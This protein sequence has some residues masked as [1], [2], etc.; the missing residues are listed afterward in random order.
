MLIKNKNK[1]GLATLAVLAALCVAG[2]YSRNVYAANIM[3]DGFTDQIFYDCVL[4]AY[5]DENPSETI[6]ATGLTPAQLGSLTQLSCNNMD[7]VSI[8]GAETLTGA[9]S[10]GLS[11]NQISDISPIADLRLLQ[12][13]SLA[14]NNII[15]ISALANLQSLRTLSLQNNN[16]VDITAIGNLHSL[17]T[18]SLQN[19][20]ISDISALATVNHL[21][22]LNISSNYV[23]DITA[24]WYGLGSH[25]HYVLDNNAIFDFWP[26]SV[27]SIDTNKT[28]AKNQ[29]AAIFAD[30]RIVE[31]PKLFEQVKQSSGNY[32]FL[33]TSTPFTISNAILSDD[34]ASITIIDLS[35]PARI[36]INDGIAGGSTYTV[37]F[38]SNLASVVAPD[39]IE[40]VTNGSAKTAK[41][42]NLPETVA[43]VLQNDITATANVYWTLS[44]SDYDPDK[45]TAQTFTVEGDIVLPDYVTNSD[46][47]PLTT[48]VTVTVLATADDDI[49]TPD[50][51]VMSSSD[52]GIKAAISIALPTLGII[53]A[54][55]F[56]VIVRRNKVGFIE[57]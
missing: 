51:G 25:I 46:S 36:V 34:N 7:I 1:A 24:L 13:L 41:G 37:Y 30:T 11:G 38:R 6:P 18:L 53:A 45:T 31:L 15:T 9:W 50:T 21:T 56:A 32:A 49:K 17:T 40:N 47:V 43:I 22:Y 35:E 12:V 3:S 33:Y 54:I 2:A 10:L 27:R 29:V 8:S 4:S 42:L 16:I 26:I 23:N 57:R 20:A 48:S 55:A 44:D 14:D 5:R 39:E 19:N 52:G 28:T